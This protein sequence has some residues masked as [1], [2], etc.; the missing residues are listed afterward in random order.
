ARRTGR[1]GFEHLLNGEPPHLL[2]GPAKN[3]TGLGMTQ[4]APLA[5]DGQ[6]DAGE[7]T[8]STAEREGDRTVL[9]LDHLTVDLGKQSLNLID[10]HTQRGRGRLGSRRPGTP[11]SDEDTEGDDTSRGRAHAG[12]DASSSPR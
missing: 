6:F 7:K 4:L 1:V 10:E 9:D 5:V 2:L 8:V 12:T 3:L 11:E